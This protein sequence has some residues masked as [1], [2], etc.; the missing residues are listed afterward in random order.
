MSK[1][2]KVLPEMLGL[3]A[4]DLNR[5]TESCFPLSLSLFTSKSEKKRKVY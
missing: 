4:T 2:V 3:W 5:S 1:N